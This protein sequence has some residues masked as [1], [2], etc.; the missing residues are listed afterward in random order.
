MTGTSELK[1]RR[2]SRVTAI[3]IARKL[4]RSSAAWLAIATLAFAVTASPAE[5]GKK[6]KKAAPEVTVV[7]NGEP[8][9]LVVSTGQ[10]KIDVYRGTDLVVTSQVSTGMAAHP[11]MIGAFSIL[12]KQ[13]W[14][15]SNIYS[16]APMPWMNRI[17]W[18]G[19]ALHAGVVPGYPAS[20]G[21]I[22][23]L[24][25]F[26][27]KL[28]NM[29]SKG[30]N[31]ITSR[32]RPKPVLIENDALFQPLPPPPLPKLAEE[33][34]TRAEPISAPLPAVAREEPATVILAKAEM[35]TTIDSEARAPAAAEESAS[36]TESGLATTDA[37]ADPNRVHAIN[38]E[39]GPSE[40]AHALPRAGD[41]PESPVETKAEAVQASPSPEPVRDAGP[42]PPAPT[43]TPTRVPPPVV[44]KVDAGI[45]AAAT[46]AA[47]PRS[48]APLRILFTRRTNRDRIIGMQ[49]IFADMGYLPE[50]NFDGTIGK[51]TVRA[52]KAFQKANGMPETGT[53]ND[54]LVTKV[55]E[56]AGKDEP[57]AGHLYVRQ[58]FDDVFDVPVNF[59]NADEPLG[60]HV[61][62]ALNFAPGDTKVRWTVIDVDDT[63]GDG[64]GALDR[65]EI[66]SDVRQKI[67]ERL[68]PGSTFIV[69]DTSINSAGLPKGG[70][71]VVLAKGTSKAKVS[72]TEGD[73]PKVRRK[74]RR[75][76]ADRRYNND[77]RYRGGP[78]FARPW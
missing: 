27:P 61:Y 18:S 66:P 37:E 25:S 21:C 54:A 78:W 15:H 69:A 31:V 51:I 60:T 3:D 9:T 29:T 10:Q 44:A 42:T 47:E 7:D 64:S 72:N 63:G 5:A 17:T 77:Y 12:E 67:S 41:K 50:L 6:Q 40:G 71:F 76:T 30:D 57:P 52:I 26:A 59:R 32:G 68:T 58:E 19:T 36:E 4:A 46:E 2:M 13:R 53:F 11:T 74:P 16:G 33:H 45:T 34:E 14:H 49:K 65:L 73:S 22:R 62:T 24:Y 39:A 23:L 70:D 1:A 38:P 55:F 8:M 43:R 75:S 35:H 48:E 56:V 20:H 28:Y